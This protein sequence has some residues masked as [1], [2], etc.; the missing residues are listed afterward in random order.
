MFSKFSGSR[1]LVFSGVFAASATI[2]AFTMSS[3]QVR[4]AQPAAKAETMQ[5]A[6]ARV[7]L[8]KGTPI[9]GKPIK[10]QSVG[11]KSS[12]DDDDTPTS[13][14]DG[15]GETAEEIG[16]ALDTMNSGGSEPVVP[17]PETPAPDGPGCYIKKEKYNFSGSVDAKWRPWHNTHNFKYVTRAG[18]DYYQH[19]RKPKR[20]VETRCKNGVRNQKKVYINDHYSNG[21]DSCR[22]TALG[23]PAGF[24]GWKRQPASTARPECVKKVAKPA[25]MTLISKNV[26]GEFKKLDRKWK[27]R[28]VVV[29]GG[30][31]Y[32][33]H[34]NNAS[35]TRPAKCEYGQYRHDYAAGGVDKCI[36]TSNCGAGAF[37]IS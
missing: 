30:R 20:R 8:D 13:A 16:E 26:T 31:D 11:N 32:F 5:R 29:P 28:L 10:A 23:C 9:K 37:F 18:R 14:N 33:R 27:Y 2:G 22:E 15:N 1:A 35:K 3:A 34:T 4:S 7:R 36:T 24:T 21:A 6:P 17:N 19:K 25:G 12:D